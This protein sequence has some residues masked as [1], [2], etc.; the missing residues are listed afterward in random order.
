MPRMHQRSRI[1]SIVISVSRIRFALRVRS[2]PS[3][4][5]HVRDQPAGTRSL[6]RVAPQ[7]FQTWMLG[8]FAAFALLL[9]AIGIY[10]LRHYAVTERT[11][12][13]AIRIAIR[14]QP[15]AAFGMVL[16][17]AA[18]L[19][20]VGIGVGTLGAL[21]V[22]SALATMLYGVSAHDPLTYVAVAMLLGGIAAAASAMPAWRANG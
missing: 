8:G 5:V 19:A 9:A 6:R 13:I 18:R 17:Q 20:A 7:R 2:G 1:A 3:Q 21:W 16:G 15:C 22:T 4:C 12:E 10:G 14:A 11:R